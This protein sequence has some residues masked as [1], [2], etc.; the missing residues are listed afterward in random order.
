M[1]HSDSKFL[2]NTAQFEN[3]ISFTASSSVFAPLT[4]FLKK[5]LPF[6]K[7]HQVVICLKTVSEGI[8]G[9]DIINHQFFSV[10]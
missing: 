6:Q 4:T 10:S 7:L 2:S 9:R 3:F 8:I 1:F 5:N